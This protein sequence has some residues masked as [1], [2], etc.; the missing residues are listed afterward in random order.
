M[1]RL[2][3]R[4]K[5]FFWGELAKYQFTQ[6]LLSPMLAALTGDTAST[7]SDVQALNRLVQAE[8]GRPE[9]FTVGVSYHTIMRRIDGGWKIQRHELQLRGTVVQ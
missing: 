9:R 3:I 1:R 5:H 2:I 8:Q 6:H 7:R 4:N